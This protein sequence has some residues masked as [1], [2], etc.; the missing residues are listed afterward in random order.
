MP[1]G[2]VLGHLGCCG[3]GFTGRC[4]WT[5]HPT[6]RVSPQTAG[7]CSGHIFNHQGSA[8][9][10]KMGNIDSQSECSSAEADSVENSA[11]TCGR[12]RKR[13]AK[14]SKAC[15]AGHTA[16][17][18]SSV[19][20]KCTNYYTRSRTN[21]KQGPLAAWKFLGRQVHSALSCNT[22]ISGQAPCVFCKSKFWAS[23]AASN[24]EAQLQ[25]LSGFDV[26]MQG[27]LKH[28]YQSGSVSPFRSVVLT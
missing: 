27:T 26:P 5:E 3:Q 21:C 23:G 17:L 25:M 22:K 2:A 1:D 28:A 20:S 14:R 13:S 16:R 12:C 19:V 8:H 24:A 15:K 9:R 18:E 4:H 11:Q 10:H 6:D 7:I